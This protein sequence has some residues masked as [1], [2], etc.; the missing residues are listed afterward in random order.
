MD[1]HFVSIEEGKEEGEVVALN[2]LLESWKEWVSRGAPGFDPCYLPGAA[3]S[4]GV[5]PVGG[6]ALKENLIWTPDIDVA[7]NIRSTF[8]RILASAM[9]ERQQSDRSSSS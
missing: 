1:V 4:A 5:G 2:D 9:A 3:N 7:E 6:W 8:S